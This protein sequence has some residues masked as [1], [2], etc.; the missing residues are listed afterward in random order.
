MQPLSQDLR[1]RIIAARERGQQTGEVCKRFGVSRKSVQRFWNQ[2]R[3]DGHCHPKKI[4]GYRQSRLA[5]H[6]QA[7]RDWIDQQ[8]DLT[9]DQI[10]ERCL[11][12][13]GVRIGINAL[14]YRLDRLGLS[15]K[16]NDARRRARSARRQARARPM[17]E[18]TT[19]V[20]LPTS[21]L[22]RRNR[23]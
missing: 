21:R 11:K 15:F 8:S 2:H 13:L 23:A 6:D 1:S 7:L 4:G 19:R 20:G 22:H 10:K 18:T 14:W 16:K 3:R 9:L 5:K 17:A 12:T